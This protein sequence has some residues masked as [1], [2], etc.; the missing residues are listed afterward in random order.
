MAKIEEGAFEEVSK[1]A[2]LKTAGTANEKVTKNLLVYNIPIEW[3]DLI[4]EHNL[5][6]RS[7]YIVQ[8]LREKLIRDGAL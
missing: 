8:A 6:T 7:G 5:G 4:K 3:L 1:G 2:A